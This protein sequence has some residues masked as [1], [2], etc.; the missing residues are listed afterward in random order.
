MSPDPAPRQ[1]GRTA[2]QAARGALVLAAL[3]IAAAAA[4]A[5]LIVRPGT[6]LGSAYALTGLPETLPLAAGSVLVL[7]L[8]A[9]GYARA[10]RTAERF[11]V[12]PEGLRVDGSAG[13][14]L[15]AWENVR[16]AA[17]TPT[18]ALA[19]KVGSREAVAATHQ[20]PP[21]RRRW[22]A[23]G[24][25]YGE[26]DYLFPRAELGVPADEALAWIEAAR[27]ETSRA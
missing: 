8:A 6:P 22:L 9:F 24:L 16:E 19:F 14:Y 23:E 3:G 12:L 5:R 11:T 17:I 4:L 20:G 1:F 13:S 25:P 15:L 18:G 21:E 2:A 7:A 26:W 10:R 27:S